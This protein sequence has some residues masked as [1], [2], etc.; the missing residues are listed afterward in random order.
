LAAIAANLSGSA[1]TLSTLLSGWTAANDFSSYASTF[2]NNSILDGYGRSTG[3]I[4]TSDTISQIEDVRGSDFND[5]IL[6]AAGTSNRFEGG[7]GDDYIDAGGANETTNTD[8]VDYVNATEG[9]TVNLALQ[10]TAQAISVSQGTDTLLNFENVRGSAFDDTLTGNSG[11]NTLEGQ[12]GD[13]TLMGGDGSDSLS[14]GSGTD[15]VDYSYRSGEIFVDLAAGTA[16]QLAGTAETDTLTSIENV[17]GT[18]FDDQLQGDANANELSG[19]AGNDSLYGFAGDDRLKAGLGADL[20]NGDS[21]GSGS[22]I[23]IYES[24]SDSG[25]GSLLRD[26]ITD[27]ASGSDTIEFAFGFNGQTSITYLGDSS[28]AF[29][30][31]TDNV[32]ELR[33][34]DTGRILQADTDDDG[35][36][37]M[38]IALSSVADA[39]N[40]T[41]NDF[42]IQTGP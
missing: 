18:A 25:V 7:G 14:G 39:D 4:G 22:D 12:D 34:D 17:V 20:L 15:T 36:A 5:V 10:G 8:R 42:H 23:F 41:A 31:G 40:L 3:V 21:G 1:V 33:F 9:V 2:F 32:L 26:T 19:G 29:T 30:A 28:N 27:F 35:I 6:G 38:E 37:D 11:N 16:N 13:D 24:T